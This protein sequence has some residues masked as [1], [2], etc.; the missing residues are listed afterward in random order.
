M[1]MATQLSSWVRQPMAIEVPRSVCL[2]EWRDKRSIWRTTMT[3]FRGTIARLAILA[4]PWYDEGHQFLAQYNI[5][6][7]DSSSL[8]WIRLWSPMP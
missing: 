5:S 2:Y 1:E 3:D 6:A 8:V 7:G 4:Y